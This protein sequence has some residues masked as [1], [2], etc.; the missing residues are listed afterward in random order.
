MNMPGM[1]DMTQDIQDSGSW[2][3]AFAVSRPRRKTGKRGKFLT[4]MFAVGIVATMLGGGLAIVQN[5]EAEAISQAK[6]NA[7]I[8]SEGG[9]PPCTHEDG[10]RQSGMCLWDARK[11]GDGNGDVVVLVPTKPGQDKRVVVLINR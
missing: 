3:Q 7:Y 2:G 11:R 6:I 4:R 10:S 8:R 1:L 9:I 5:M